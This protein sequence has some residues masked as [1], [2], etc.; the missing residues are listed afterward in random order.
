MRTSGG[1]AVVR[2]VG[3]WSLL[4]GGAWSME[5]ESPAPCGS[6]RG[7]R[8]GAR[9]KRG[10]PLALVH[11]HRHP[12]FPLC[13]TLTPRPQWFEVH[14]AERACRLEEDWNW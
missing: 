2:G 13:F 10:S 7:R 5:H 1:L 4:R 11:T 8:L 3:S 6:T 12:S 14:D 9:L